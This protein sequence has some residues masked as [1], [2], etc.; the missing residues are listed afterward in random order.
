MLIQP[1]LALIKP[2]YFF[3]CPEGYIFITKLDLCDRVMSVGP[4]GRLHKYLHV[5]LH[6]YLHVKLHKYLHVKLQDTKLM[7][8]KGG[9]VRLIN[10]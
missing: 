2:G 7:T 5:K 3:A 8:H 4:P 1:A 10:P 9:R 6:K